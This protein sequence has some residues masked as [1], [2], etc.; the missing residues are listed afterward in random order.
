MKKIILGLC[1]VSV[2][3]QCGSG[4]QH[5]ENTASDSYTEKV[6]EEF[7]PSSAAV[8]IKNDSSRKFIRTADLKFRVK[9]VYQASTKIEEIT[10]K[11]G[12]FVVNTNLTS[13]V[14]F[15]ESVPVSSDSSLETT[16]F[17][18]LNEIVLRVPNTKLDTTLKQISAFID[19]LDYRNIKAQDVGLDLLANDLTQS[20]VTKTGKR[21]TNAV[22]KNG[23]KLYETTYAEDVILSRGHEADQAR[24]ANMALKDQI[25]FSTINLN[26]YQRPSIKRVLVSNDK[27]IEAY[28]PSFWSKI[29]DSLKSGWKV[30]EVFILFITK[31]W[32]FILGAI[33]I[34]VLYRVFGKKLKP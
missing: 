5:A 18:V 6:A 12:G 27:N 24:L 16:H 15:V 10:R 29:G 33:V 1:I 3:F 32:G 2:F 23:K 13:E 9:S 19:Y 22:D 28:E 4:G 11:E 20:R 7:V 25:N 26:I 8:V 30:F 17:T 21:I 34:F 31:L 14:N